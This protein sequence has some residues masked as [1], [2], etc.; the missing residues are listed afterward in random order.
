MKKRSDRQ[1]VRQIA[2]FLVDAKYRKRQ[3]EYELLCL[4]R[5][6]SDATFSTLLKE[7]VHKDEERSK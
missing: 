5:S 7:V 1:A 3:R 4:G 6:A 2:D